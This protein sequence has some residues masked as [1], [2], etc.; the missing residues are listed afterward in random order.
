MSD[1]EHWVEDMWTQRRGTEEP[2][3]SL[4]GF[5]W[6]GP[7]ANPGRVRAEWTAAL[8]YHLG[9]P[10]PAPSLPAGRSLPGASP[11][12]FVPKD[13]YLAD[14]YHFAT[15]EDTYANYFIHVSPRAGSTTRSSGATEV[16]CEVVGGKGLR[17]W[18]WGRLNCPHF[19]PPGGAPLSPQL[20]EIQADYH[21]KSLS[22]LDTAL[23]ELRENHSQTGGDLTPTPVPHPALGLLRSLH[24]IPKGTGEPGTSSV[25]GRAQ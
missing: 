25:Q 19:P 11:A 24:S 21:R 16:P 23:A 10:L 3:K 14:L 4:E 18:P 2:L 15:K 7:G 1:T 8:P 12:L 20:M 5:P 22:S 17:L 13:E 9:R 6:A